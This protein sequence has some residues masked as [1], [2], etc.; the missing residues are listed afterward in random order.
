MSS[1][2]L[3]PAPRRLT[4][5]DAPAF[6]D[7][8]LANRGY[9]DPWVDTPMRV[10]SLRDAEAALAATPGEE[11]FGTFLESELVASVKVMW[12]PERT[13]CELGFWGVQKHRGRGYVLSTVD[14]VLSY[15]LRRGAVAITIRHSN[16]NL[17][18]LNLVQG[19]VEMKWPLSVRADGD[20]MVWSLK[21]G[22]EAVPVRRIQGGA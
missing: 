9:L 13:E 12:N 1:V 5:S 15:L 20:Q 22:I 3:M 7:A 21:T 6:L 8:V 19:L 17:A 18:C 11:R 14:W 2:R 4:E 16:A 10:Q